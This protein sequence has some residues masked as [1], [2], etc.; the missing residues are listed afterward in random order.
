MND[1]FF[2][3]LIS[4]KNHG[5]IF[6]LMLI[7]W[8]VYNQKIESVVNPHFHIWQKYNLLSGMIINSMCQIKKEF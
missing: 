1:N 2:H 6:C 7:F 3:A 8:L 4:N 5:I